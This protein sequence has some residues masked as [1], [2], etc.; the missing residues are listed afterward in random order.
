[1]ATLHK[2]DNNIIIIIIIILADPRALRCAP[3]LLAPNSSGD[4]DVGRFS[5]TTKYPK[6]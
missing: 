3:P 1:M 5:S 2:G 6:F 4:M